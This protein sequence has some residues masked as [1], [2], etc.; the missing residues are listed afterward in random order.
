[1]KTEKTITKQLAS[2]RINCYNV[3]KDRT[4]KAEDVFGAYEVVRLLE[5]RVTLLQNRKMI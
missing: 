1:M 4:S 5:R 3:E 2:A